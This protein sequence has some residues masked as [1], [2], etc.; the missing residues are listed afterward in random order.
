MI[1]AF[2][3]SIP[4]D[5]QKVSVPE[6]D[7]LLQRL[8]SSVTALGVSRDG[9]PIGLGV[10]H[11]QEQSP[12]AHLLALTIEE[13]QR[14]QGHG[15]LLL[16]ALESS[17]RQNGVER[18]SVEYVASSDPL[19]GEAAFLTT[20][21]FAVPRPGIYIRSGSLSLLHNFLWMK[22]TTL[23]P[24]FAV[25]AWSTLTEEE[26]AFVKKGSGVW[27]PSILSPFADEAL[28]DPDRSLVLRYRGEVAGWMML[29]AF[30]SQ[31]VLF[32][33]MFVHR[34]HQRMARGAALIA[35]VC[36]RV[37]EEQT[38]QNGILFVEAENE[39][40]VRFMNRHLQHEEL[41]KEVLWRTV[42]KL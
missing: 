16:R 37:L 10:A 13:R 30:D 42:K 22:K 23:P 3:G 5:Y 2:T 18:L 27:Y 8:P 1:E 26:R 21:G 14:R 34:R 24:S 15:R 7:Y 9:E 38:F 11:Q 32:K 40:M 35:E 20:C 28:I 25:S 12:T 4:P 41:Q 33:T 36:H 31:T 29:E 19:S 6:I 39:E 17:L